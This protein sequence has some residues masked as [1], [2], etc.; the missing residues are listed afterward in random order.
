MKWNIGWGTVSTCNMKC[1]FC[2]SKSVR[3]SS[4][5]LGYNEWINFIDENYENIN[6]INYGTGENTISD[7]WFKLIDHISK[8]YD[9]KQ[10]LTTNGFISERVKNNKKLKEIFL[11]SINEVDVSLD[12]AIKEKHNNLR[13]QVNAYDWALNTL[14]FCKEHNI[15]TTIVFLGTNETLEI[16]N[17]EGLFNIAKKYGCKL[18]MNL[19]R[20]THGIDDK[21]KIYIPEFE[22]IVRS[23]EWINKEHTIL[24]IDDPLFGSLL[25]EGYQ[26]IDP[27]GSQ[28]LRILADGS[29]TP[30]TY[31][32][33]EDFVLGNIT[34]DN[35]RDIKN[36]CNFEYLIPESC[37]KCEDVESCKGG[38]LDRRVLWNGS[39]NSPDPYCYKTYKLKN[40]V[41]K[42]NLIEHEKFESIHHG[43]L[44]TM[45]FEY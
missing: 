10:A 7:D 34:K 29:I 11:K 14:E 27:S 17:L 2:Y 15:L 39:F 8:N 40:K 20:P 28:S 43:Y 44:P 30:S 24:S 45:F 18:R 5:D 3:E 1:G 26:G 22:K 12:F 36:E 13:G 4:V 16:K 41:K 19:F 21:S 32:I 35:L 25:V 33:S 37:L 38:V 9:I 42:F 23:L 6:A 31:L